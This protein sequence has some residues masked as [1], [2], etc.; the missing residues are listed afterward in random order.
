MITPQQIEQISFNRAT[1]GG[2]DMQSVDEFLGPLT[3]DYITL[4]KENALLKSKMRV[5]VGKLEEYRQSDAS[6]KESANIA[7]RTCDNLIKETEEKCAKMLADASN[8][9]AERA[10]DAEAQIAEENARVDDARRLAAS[11]IDELTEQLRTCLQ[12][13]ENI[14]IANR[15]TKAAPYDYDSESDP[16]PIDP[17]DALADEIAQSLEALMGTT[18]DIAPKADPQHPGETVTNSKFAGLKFGPNY[19]PTQRK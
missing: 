10:K 8:A 1:F 9:A 2:Y 17:A 19:D 5:L 7:Q 15:P 18:A 4:Y 16:A 6:M 13:L 3:E 14:K 11:Q 12:A